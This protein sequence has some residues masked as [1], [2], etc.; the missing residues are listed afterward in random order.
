LKEPEPGPRLSVICLPPVQPCPVPI[1]SPRP[2]F[3]PWLAPVRAQEPAQASLPTLGLL[4]SLVCSARTYPA[5]VV[6]ATLRHSTSCGK[7]LPRP[8]YSVP[9]PDQAILH[10]NPFPSPPI[11][12]PASIGYSASVLRLPSSRSKPSLR[13]LPLLFRVGLFSCASLLLQCLAS[14]AAYLGPRSFAAVLV[15]RASLPA[16]LAS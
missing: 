2:F 12:L 10:S 1:T 11:T 9:C 8:P 14:P 15:S 3:R 5:P 6:T 4:L 13:G 7:P 16:V